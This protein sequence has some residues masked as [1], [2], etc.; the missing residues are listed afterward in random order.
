MMLNIME[1]LEGL[2][3]QSYWPQIKQS[4]FIFL[5]SLML[6]VYIF[7]AVAEVPTVAFVYAFAGVHLFLVT[8]LLL[9]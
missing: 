3:F 2:Q 1:V 8:V 7:L 4:I 6:Q 5:A 9:M